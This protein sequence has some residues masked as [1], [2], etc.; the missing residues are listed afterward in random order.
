MLTAPLRLSME[1][2]GTN[3]LLTWP[4]GALLEAD[5]LGGPWATNVTAVSPHTVKPTNFQKFYR[6]R[7]N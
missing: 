3:Y 2:A 4:A 1:R 7:L 6:L 5:T